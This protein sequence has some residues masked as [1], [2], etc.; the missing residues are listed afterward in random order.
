M[1]LAHLR[2]Q[3]LSDLAK[4]RIVELLRLESW[5]QMITSA[6]ENDMDLVDYVYSS[7][8]NHPNVGELTLDTV[9]TVCSSDCISANK[10]HIGQLHDFVHHKCSM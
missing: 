4:D 2:L 9:R 7:I 5:D 3:L 6:I 1:D 10:E 8:S